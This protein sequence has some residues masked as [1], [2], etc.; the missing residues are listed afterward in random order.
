VT[1]ATHHGATREIAERIA[2]ILRRSGIE[3]T[4]RDVDRAGDLDHYDAFVV[5]SAVY[6]FSWLRGAQEF[7]RRH[8]PIL[9]SRPTWLFSSGPLGTDGGDEQDPRLC[10][11]PREIG[12]VRAAL[13]ARDHRVFLGAYDP[14]APPIGPLEKATRLMPTAS[15][16][17][18]AGDWRDWHEIDRWAASIATALGDVAADREF[19]S[20]SST[21]AFLEG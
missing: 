8:Q 21:P 9:A 7:V 15:H 4:C 13:R 17:Y 2:S 14:D 5:G 11:G 3:V 1:Y 12:Q 10:P 19:A 6:V 20:P 18:P 16:A